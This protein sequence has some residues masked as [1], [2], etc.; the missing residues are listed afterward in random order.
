MHRVLVIPAETH[1][2]D[3]SFLEE[4][5]AK[6]ERLQR[7]F[8]LR[9]R[10]EARGTR[11]RWHQAYVETMP[12]RSPVRL[13]ATLAVYLLDLRY[14]PRLW[15]H[16]RTKAID[17]VYV[18]DLTF[19]LLLALV[20]RPWARWSVIYQKSFP[21]ELRWFDPEQ[22]ARYRLPWLFVLARRIEGP[23][24]RALLRRCDVVVPIST[25]M[26]TD[27]IEQDGCK[28]ERVH[29]FGM[30][31]TR[32]ALETPA[33][34]PRSAGDPLRLV[35]VGTLARSR[36][37][38]VLLDAILIA[39]DEFGVDVTLTI[40]GGTDDEVSQMRADV[41]ERSLGDWVV[42]PGRVPRSEVYAL[43]ARHH[44][45]AI[46]IARDPRFRVASTTKL[47]EGLVV[48]QPCIC[49][50]S[51]KMHSEVAAAYGTVILTDDT[52]RGF[53]EGIED[54]DRR[55]D[56]VAI[57]ARE[58]R[59][60]VYADYAYDAARERM[61][62]LISDSVDRRRSHGDLQTDEPLGN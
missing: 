36:R 33:P 49:T 53:A 2:T 34:S 16:A 11:E 18:R 25:S 24:L 39:R 19:P 48:G 26:A 29:V 17:A 43:M 23:L 56:E 9:S 22:V 38:N 37:L 52:A 50:D 32:S 47:L 40:L 61:D 10:T 60:R 59:E 5:H 20:L 15:E 51:V 31:V 28:K 57:R 54:L 55:W 6:S 13:M 35:Y 44:A 42:V 3:H 4:V 58:L 41:S 8:L 21:H 7:H 12:L 30:G 1:P 27:L 46:Y 62:R 45:S 14:L